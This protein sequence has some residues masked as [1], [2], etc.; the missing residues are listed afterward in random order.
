MKQWNFY[1][2]GILNGI[3]RDQNDETRIAGT[4]GPDGLRC[5]HLR[6]LPPEVDRAKPGFRDMLLAGIDA[7][8]LGHPIV[9]RALVPKGNECDR[10]AEQLWR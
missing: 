7:P 2:S 4:F 8:K 9:Q 5:H 3:I 6:A 10:A 1:F